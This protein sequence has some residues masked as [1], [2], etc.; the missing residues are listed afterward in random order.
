[1]T[2]PGTTITTIA[3]PRR[4]VPPT[5]TGVWMPVGITERGPIVPTPVRSLA[6]AV[7]K[8]GARV[9]YGIL[10][11]A[12][13]TFFSERGAVALV[14]RVVGPA[15]V[16]ATHT[17][18]DSVAAPSIRVDAANPGDWANT[19]L[20][21]EI[22]AGASPG[23]YV[24]IVRYDGAEVDR[25]SDLID[26]QAAVDWAAHS[27]WI[28]VTALGA[29]DPA[30][31]APAALTA[32]TDDRAAITDAQ[33]QAA[34]DR[35]TRD[36]GP[37]QVSM[38]G[39]YSLVARTALL[40]HARDRNRFALL[41]GD[42]AASRSTIVSNAAALRALGTELARRGQTFARWGVAPGIV[43]GT[44]RPVPYSAVQAGMYSRNDATG[45]VGDAVAG[46]NGTSLY[47]NDLSA[48]GAAWTDADLEAL[49]NAGVT[50]PRNFDGLIQT[51]DDVTLVDQV[52]DERW[53]E[54]STNRLAMALTAEG[55]A[56]GDRHMFRKIDGQGF[57]LADFKTDLVAMLRRRW[58]NRELYGATPADAF[59]VNTDP[60]VNTVDSINRRKLRAQIA[61]KPARTARQVEI[62]L[63]NTDLTEAL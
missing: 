1:V 36:Y 21:V 13:D 46:D 4:R 54:A 25:S 16:V 53:L 7:S 33:W 20:T 60:P 11:D 23:Y 43:A 22:A 8:F 19:R 38:P 30:V 51:Y 34:L 35:Y 62:E 52:L 5:D 15:A 44:S 28:R 29:N 3:A 57:E 42:P 18:N 37:G 14:S 17:F 48:N 59:A 32:G 45:V 6:E 63:G 39:R 31:T 61:F 10:Y 56:I 9:N 58:V 47:L 27:D 2:L 26:V 12:L 55:N 50:V 49:A 41:D 24:I 40:T